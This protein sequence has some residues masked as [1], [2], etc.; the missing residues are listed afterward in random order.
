MADIFDLFKKIETKKDTPDS[1]PTHIIAGLGNPGREYERTRHNAGFLAL[2]YL[3]DK[4]GVSCTRAKFNA[5]CTNAKLGKYSVLMMKP[6][7][8]MNLSGEAIRAAADFY[9][10]PPENILVLVD[11]IY[12]DAGRMRVRK[13]GSHGGHNGLKNIEATLGTAN[14]PRIRLGVGQK[15]SPQ[16]DLVSW[17]LGVMPKE[18]IEKLVSCFALI[19]KAAE[20]IFA[21]D[22]EKAMGLCNG[23]R[24]PEKKTES[25]S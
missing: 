19:D 24:P 13:D 10:I 5:L 18:E 1:A 16:Y 3:A 2:D 4:L 17:V 8:F 23:H 9:K 6:Q 7:T 15:P 11:D 14:Y 20:M 21:G 22:I 12:Q 25:D